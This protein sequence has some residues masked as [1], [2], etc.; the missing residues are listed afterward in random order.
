[1]LLHNAAVQR[2]KPTDIQGATARVAKKASRK[3][4][5]IASRNIR[6]FSFFFTGT[7][8]GKF[9]VVTKFTTTA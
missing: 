1:M 7:F 6:R 5:S 2:V 9:A 4:L 3:L 8:C